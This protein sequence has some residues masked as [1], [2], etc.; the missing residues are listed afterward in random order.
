MSAGRF[1]SQLFATISL[2]GITPGPA[3]IGREVVPQHAVARV[4][5]GH[6]TLG[7]CEADSSARAIVA[8]RS[9]SEHLGYGVAQCKATAA[10][11]SQ[12]QE[13]MSQSTKSRAVMPEAIGN[14]GKPAL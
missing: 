8:E 10:L 7:V 1:G 3:R 6:A 14:V 12:A 9:G 13:C 2:S 11:R 5:R 4:A